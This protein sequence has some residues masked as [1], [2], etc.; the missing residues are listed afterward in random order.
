MVN[1]EIKYSVWAVGETNT[2]ATCNGNPVTT[3]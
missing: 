2:K 1:G 3:R